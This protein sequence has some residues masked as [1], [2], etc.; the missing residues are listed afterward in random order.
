MN[1]ELGTRIHLRVDF[2][3]Y[4]LVQNIKPKKTKKKKQ[5]NY[6]SSL[7]SQFEDEGKN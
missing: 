1:K 7:H 2:K 4:I 3:S 6:K 5:E